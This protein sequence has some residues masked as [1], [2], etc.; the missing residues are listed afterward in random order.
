MAKPVPSKV[1]STSTLDDGLQ[2]VAADSELARL[3]EEKERLELEL[4]AHGIFGNNPRGL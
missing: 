2:H 3:Q 1:W 4:Q